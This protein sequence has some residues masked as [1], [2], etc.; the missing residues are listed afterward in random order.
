MHAVKARVCGSGPIWNH[1]T[2]TAGADVTEHIHP[3]CNQS[4]FT[5]GPEFTYEPFFF[6][7]LMKNLMSNRMKNCCY[8]CCHCHCP[9]ETQRR[10]Q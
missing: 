3:K 4:G 1:S 6:D 9:R 10:L 2:A 7:V 8:C 5:E